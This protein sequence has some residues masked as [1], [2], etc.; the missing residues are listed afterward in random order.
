MLSVVLLFPCMIMQV[1]SGALYG[2]TKGWLVGGVCLYGAGAYGTWGVVKFLI[3][4]V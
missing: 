3:I 2:F 1:I 4:P